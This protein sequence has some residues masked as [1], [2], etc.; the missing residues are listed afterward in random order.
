MS[1]HFSTMNLE[2]LLAERINLPDIRE[3]IEWT[4]E[5]VNNKVKLW[6]LAHSHDRLTSAN[7]LWVMTHLRHT[8]KA[9]FESLQNDYID[10]L[11]NERDTAKKRMILQILREQEYDAENI[12]TDFLDY[13]M[14]KINS[15]CE[16]YAIRC[17]SIYVAFNMCR[18]FPELIKELDEYLD[19]M[20]FQT[21]SPG[22]KSALRQTKTKINKLK[23]VNCI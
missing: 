1:T 5:D 19:M 23:R 14:K 22:L 16:P 10:M 15:E 13:C 11:M 21:L 8:E 2:Q 4:K 20:S 9:W 17:F 7:A 3:I 12:R 6:Q 18:Y